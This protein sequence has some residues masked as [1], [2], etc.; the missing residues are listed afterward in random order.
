MAQSDPSLLAGIPTLDIRA[1][2]H[3]D[4]Q[5]KAA[6]AAAL[7][8]AYETIGFAAIHGHGISDDL[9]ARLYTESEG[10]FALPAEAKRKYAR[11]EA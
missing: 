9:I 11:P 5:E 4:E 1:F 6:F 3:G 10:F 8:E 2:I 7:G